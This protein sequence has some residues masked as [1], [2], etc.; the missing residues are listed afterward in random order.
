[1]KRAV[2]VVGA[3]FPLTLMSIAAVV[4]GC[5]PPGATFTIGSNVVLYGMWN[6]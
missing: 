5:T 3:V 6:P 1:M 4:L 2:R